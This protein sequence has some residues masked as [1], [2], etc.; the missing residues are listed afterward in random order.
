M[1][2]RVVFQ[3]SNLLCVKCDYPLNKDLFRIHF[4]SFELKIF[5]PVCFDKAY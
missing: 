5:G 4:K 3:M 1:E 2:V